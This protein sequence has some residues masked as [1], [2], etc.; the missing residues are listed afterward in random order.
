[1][2]PIGKTMMRWLVTGAVALLALFIFAS[3]TPASAHG[4]AHAH[5]VAAEKAVPD[6]V[7]ALQAPSPE[8]SGHGK[9]CTGGAMCCNFGHCVG[10]AGVMP[11]TS[12]MTPT[13]STGSAPYVL[14]SRP[15]LS[16]MRS[17]PATPPP[18]LDA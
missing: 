9:P 2:Q 16:M 5:V 1:M 10:N 17:G 18:R 11:Q 12:L 6:V 7:Q 15:A 8:P 4:T 13:G 3:I 14:S